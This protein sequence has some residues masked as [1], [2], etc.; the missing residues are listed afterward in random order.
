MDPPA[1]LLS[2]RRIQ[3]A[4][5][6]IASLKLF[7][8]L[9]PQQAV[10]Y[11]YSTYDFIIVGGG[12]AGSVLANRL[13][14]DKNINVLLIE[15]GDDPSLEVLL[16][17][18]FYL[19]A[20]SRL[21]WNY[22][23]ESTQY[24]QCHKGRVLHHTSGKVLGGSS[25]VGY[26]FY[27][28]GS[29]FDYQMWATVAN[30]STW[31]W[32]GVFPYF[33]KSER[34]EDSS[35]FNSP[36]KDSHGYNGYLG[37]T[38]EPTNDFSK[39]LNGF[40]EDGKSEVFDINGNETIG[41][42]NQW[43]TIAGGARQTTAFAYITPV[44]GRSNLHVMKNAVATKILFD[45]NNNA[46]GV[47]AITHNNETFVLKASREVVISA[48]AFNTPQLL[49]LSGIGPEEHLR[50]L[51]INV[52]SNLPVGYNLQDHPLVLLSILTERSNNPPPRNDPHNFPMPTLTG[53]VALNKAQINP[54]YQSINFAIPNDSPMPNTFCSLLIG[55]YNDI[56][57]TLKNGVKDRKSIISLINL[58]HPKSRGRVMLRSASPREPPLIY[59]GLFSDESDLEDLVSYIK[60]FTGVVNTT[61][62]KDMNAELVDLT[63]SRCFGFKLWSREYWRCYIGC[64]VSTMHDYSGTCA[65]GMVVDSRLR[66]RGVRRLRVVDASVM[67]SLIGGNILAAV[68]MIAE[69]AA[70]MIKRDLSMNIVPSRPFINV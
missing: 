20:E 29:P 12:A 16:A 68:V 24:S 9:F 55:F 53:Y 49:M 3:I 33:L 66:V 65:M 26:M 22:T 46:I 7:S 47:E 35:I 14:E 60:D 62:F 50:V 1:T 6:L 59:S 31:N 63:G 18:M 56:C 41:Y 17:G 36:L 40:K 42:T 69:K 58:L 15:A 52:R 27:G 25:S 70:D 44:R 67:P 61:H 43:F 23:S 13:T 64:M 34:L 39:Y 11:D 4:L 51:N 37:V 8:Y 57:Q 21:D 48:G 2:I 19:T 54:D 38:R 30:D 10:V 5:Q 32:D 45:N 28:R